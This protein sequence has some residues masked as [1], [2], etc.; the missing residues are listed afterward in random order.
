MV[1]PLIFRPPLATTVRF[2]AVLP[3]VPAVQLNGPPSVS[4]PEPVRVPPL[5]TYNPLAELLP[6]SPSA[7]IPEESLNVC[8][9]LVPPKTRLVAA[10][11]ATF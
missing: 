6:P 10:A 1:A 11:A 8:V 3:R 4:V 5:S 9:P 2:E 7:N